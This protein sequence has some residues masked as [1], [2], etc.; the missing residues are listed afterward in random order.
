MNIEILRIHKDN[1]LTTIFTLMLLSE[2]FS[3]Q[4]ETKFSKPIEEISKEELNV[5]L[6]SF[7]RL[8]EKKM[9]YCQFTN[10]LD[11][12]NFSLTDS[13]ASLSNLSFQ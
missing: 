12:C 11:D 9:A 3:R 1:I 5:V 2:R 4:G 6:K 7:A 8:R 10:V 13:L